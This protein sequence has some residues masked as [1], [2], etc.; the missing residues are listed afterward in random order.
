MGHAVPAFP[1]S[2][3]LEPEICGEIND[4]DPSL[5]QGQYLGHGS[6]VRSSEKHQPALSERLNSQWTELEIDITPQMRK[7]L[8][9]L[10][11]CLGTGCDHR[12]LSLGMECQQTHKLCA[13]VSR[14]ANDAY[15]NH[16]NYPKNQ[17][18]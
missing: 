5:K 3:V 17:V 16:G 18:E 12:Q 13:C 10:D 2:G 1:G 4:P 11:T 14:P 6:P 9:H 7:D 15:L 8:G